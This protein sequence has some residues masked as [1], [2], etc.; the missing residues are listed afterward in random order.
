M[1]KRTFWTQRRCTGL[2][3]MLGCVL[4][5]AG[6][7]M[8]VT[9]AQGTFIYA[10]PPRGWLQVVFTHPALWQ[11]TNVLFFSGTVVTLLGLA[12]LTTQFRAAGDRSWSQLA[13]LAFLLGSV[14]WVINL[15]F[16]LGVDPLAAQELAKTGM[17]PT[18]YL[19]LLLWTRVLFVIYTV[20]AFSALAA[21]GGAVLTTHVLPSW[22]GW[23]AILYGLAGLGVL[24]FTGDA[25]PF[26]HHL[27]LIVI[28]I[29]LLLRRY[30]LP[31]GSHR[32]E[33]V[34]IASPAL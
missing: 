31:R 11:W 24:G 18:Y 12:L 26:L 33:E 5:L 30:Q 19:P 15:A 9:D 17:V 34:S 6:S 25:P 13:L 20:L 14:F 8:P 10:L 4:F 23:T 2:T 3:L 22:V 29:L 28:G 27:L 16:R 7:S 1:S 32:E 21:F